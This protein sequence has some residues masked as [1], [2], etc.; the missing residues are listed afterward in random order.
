MKYKTLF[1]SIILCSILVF[2]VSANHKPIIDIN[3]EAQGASAVDVA[4]TVNVKNKAG[5]SNDIIAVNIY[6]PPGYSI[7]SCVNK[8]G[9]NIGISS[10][11]LCGFISDGDVITPK[12]SADFNI[13]VSTPSLEDYYSWIIDT[14]DDD[15]VMKSAQDS[16][17]IDG[18]PPNA[19]FK[20]PKPN[21]WFKPL[22]KFNVIIS[23]EDS[24]PSAGLWH[25]GFL[26]FKI[27]NAYGELNLLIGILEFSGNPS[28]GIYTAY[29][30]FSGTGKIY[31]PLGIPAGMGELEAWIYDSVA[32]KKIIS[33]PIGLNKTI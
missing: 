16:T 17:F 28:K 10:N 15:W 19:I 4:L 18:T 11:S 5:S 7:S 23:A 25:T 3:P 14:T 21:S 31:F 30:F 27:N 20:S 22:E 24:V 9:W 2:S 26:I 8:P 1:I 12:N 13:I 33:I 6:A 32:N 29:S